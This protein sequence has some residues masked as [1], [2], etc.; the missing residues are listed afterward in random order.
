MAGM[1]DYLEVQLRKHMFR[2]GSY[3]KPSG[4]W[5]ALCTTAPTDA[6][7][8]STI[9]EPSGGYARQE[10]DPLDANW[11][12]PDSTGGVTKNQSIL[13]FGPCTGSDWA[14][15][16]HFAICDALTVGNMLF[17]GALA[18]PKTVQVG[19]TFSFAVDT[20]TVTFD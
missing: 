12:A 1:S 18:V 4:L 9:V 15:A 14:S 10:L 13:T 6:S 17:W 8:G 5:L 7:T 2:T 16:T 19:D 11:S 20:V 3:T